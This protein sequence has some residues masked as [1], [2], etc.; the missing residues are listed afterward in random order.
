MD[1]INDVVK[2]FS[3]GSIDDVTGSEA[4]GRA[5]RGGQ[6]AAIQSEREMF[7]E[8]MGFQRELWD[9]QKQ[10]AKPWR[11]AG[12]DALSQYQGMGDFEFDYT[13]DPVYKARLEQMSKA[14]GASGAASG[15]QLSGRTLGAL[16][17]AT[18]SELGSSYG[19][20]F[21]EYQQRLNNLTNLINVGSGVSTNLS[22]VGQ[23][24]GASVTGLQ[25]N[26]GAAQ[27]QY[28][29]NIG[30]INAAQAQSGWNSLVQVGQFIAALYGGM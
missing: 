21:G 17:E 15:M 5:Q 6:A 9:W 4:A 1:I 11:A 12:L 8:S 27:S 2:V 13:K 10:Q 22:N 26:F 24:Y 30:Q 14:I 3:L 25:Q 19:R 29:Q 18:A 28:H 16:R 7:D 23:N 20:Q